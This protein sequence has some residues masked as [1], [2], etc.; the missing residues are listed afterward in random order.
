[1]DLTPVAVL[2]SQGESDSTRSVSWYRTRFDVVCQRFHE[3]AYGMAF[4]QVLCSAPKYPGKENPIAPAV[5]QIEA[6]E[7]E[8][9]VGMASVLPIYLPDSVSGRPDDS[10]HYSQTTHDWIGEAFGRAASASTGA[11]P[12]DETIVWGDPVGISQGEQPPSQVV[13][14]G[15]SGT[16]Y[17]LN[18]EWTEIGTDQYR[19]TALSGAPQGTRISPDLVV[20]A[21]AK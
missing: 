18:A 7:A 13:C 8:E 16:M 20:Y 17:S 6:S 2:W 15:T 12:T 14:Y 3:G 4:P 21:A 5:A 1:M 10:I 11:T 19:T 9:G